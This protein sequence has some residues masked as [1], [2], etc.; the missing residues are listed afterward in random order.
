[1]P[2]LAKKVDPSC[3]NETLPFDTVTEGHIDGI[4]FQVE[5]V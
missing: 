2:G 5:Q 3:S 4:D 1:M